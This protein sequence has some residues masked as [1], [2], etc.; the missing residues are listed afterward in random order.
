LTK[1]TQSSH[2]YW[3]GKQVEKKRSSQVQRIKE[4][5]KKDQRHK[6]KRTEICEKE[7]LRGNKK[8]I[9]RKFERKI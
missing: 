6:G 2:G 4:E 9:K 3:R 1:Y 7:N 5:K 8:N